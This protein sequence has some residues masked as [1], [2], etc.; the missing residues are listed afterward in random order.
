MRNVSDEAEVADKVRIASAWQ[1]RVLIRKVR[2]ASKMNPMLPVDLI[3]LQKDLWKGGRRGG[4]KKTI[5]SYTN[6]HK[7]N[8]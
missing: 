5:F 7:F 3:G 1:E 4:N 2:L 6:K 8:I